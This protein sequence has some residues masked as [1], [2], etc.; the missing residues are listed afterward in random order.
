M[1]MTPLP[2][3]AQVESIEAAVA[4][5]ERIAAAMPPEDGVACFNR[6][7]L[8]VTKSVLATIHQGEFADSAFMGR[9]DVV[10]ANLY[11]QAVNATATN[12]DDVPPAWSPLMERRDRRDIEPIQFALAGMNAHINHDLPIAVVTTCSELHREPDSGSIRADYTKVDRLLDAAEQTIRQSFESKLELSADRHV[13]AVAD[14]VGN[15]SI[16]TARDTAWD[17]A[18]VLWHLKDLTLLRNLFLGTL[19]R[20]VEIAGRGLLVAPCLPT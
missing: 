20:G 19:A 10:F 17:N 9:L 2:T 7:Y 8:E 16:N 6:M 1:P 12:S 11:F 5:M 13:Q 18:I 3:V 4:T 15:W 14:I